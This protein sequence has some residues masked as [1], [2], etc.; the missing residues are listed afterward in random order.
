MDIIKQKYMK[1]YSCKVYT[2]VRVLNTAFCQLTE[3]IDI[4]LS[5]LV[6]IIFVINMVT[7]LLS[8]TAFLNSF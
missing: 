7:L 4:A 5:N 1:S 8:F 2:H 3:Y 6:Y